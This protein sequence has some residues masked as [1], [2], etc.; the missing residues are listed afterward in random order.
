MYTLK[1]FNISGKKIFEKMDNVGLTTIDMTKFKRGV[2]FLSLENDSEKHI[3][4]LIKQ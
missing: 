4:K 3:E 2:Y 1:I